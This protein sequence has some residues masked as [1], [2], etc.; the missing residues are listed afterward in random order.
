MPF[1]SDSDPYLELASGAV[2]KLQSDEPHAWD[3]NDI[4]HSLGNQCR[5]TGH[6]RHFYSVAEHSVLCSLLA[7]ELGLCD[8][9]EAL[10][11]DAHESVL[12][13]MAAP[14]KP[15]LPDYKQQ[16]R[17]WAWDLRA[18]FNLPPEN[19]EGCRKIDY[20]A[21]FVEAYWL[22]KSRGDGWVDPLNV[23][24]DALRLVKRDGWH[25][26][27]LD[28]EQA[29]NAFLRRF[30]ELTADRDMG[31]PWWLELDQNGPDDDEN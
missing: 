27:G 24:V 29:K 14:W 6:C 19:T 12:S 17:K 1:L 20:M 22:L 21:L 30:H 23:R 28:P 16:E 31:D 8:P 11:H 3:I 9:F 18:R 4:A 15:L 5:F 13:D 7:E 10:M 2:F 25:I 26:K